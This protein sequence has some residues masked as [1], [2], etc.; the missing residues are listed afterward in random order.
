MKVPNA[1]EWNVGT[2]ME[3]RAMLD[4]LVHHFANA[5]LISMLNGELAKWGDLPDDEVST[6]IGHLAKFA[7]D[8]PEAAQAFADMWLVLQAVVNDHLGGVIKVYADAGLYGSTE[9]PNTIPEEW[10]G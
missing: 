10:G 4:E 2:M 7:E 6:F 5:T 3:A 8:E 1:N 9:A